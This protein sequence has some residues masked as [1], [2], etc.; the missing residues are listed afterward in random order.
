MI[1]DHKLKCNHASDESGY[2]MK[3]SRT[4]F[5]GLFQVPPPEKGDVR[6]EDSEIN[7]AC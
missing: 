1:Y 5:S 4:N 7:E 6:D 2:N 3:T